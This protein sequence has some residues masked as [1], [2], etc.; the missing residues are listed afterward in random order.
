MRSMPDTQLDAIFSR[1]K[2]MSSPLWVTNTQGYAPTALPLTTIFT[3]GVYDQSTGIIQSK[4]ANKFTLGEIKPTF[5]TTRQT[6]RVTFFQT[7]C[8]VPVFAVMNMPGYK[9]DA[10]NILSKECYPVY[11]LDES[12]NQ[13]MN[14]EGFDV[15]PQQEKDSVLPNWVNALIFG[16][17]K[18][19]ETLKSYYIESDQG[20]ILSGGLLELGQRR[21]LAF[22]QFQLKG[23]DKEVEQN[24]QEMI[25]TQG[26]PA[27]TDIIK[28]A[29]KDIRNYVTK[30]AQLSAIELDRVLA[31]DSSYQM[32][33]E[34]LEKEVYYLK[35]LDL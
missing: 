32:V 2:D 8:Y 20:D 31:K 12:W 11:Y 30:Y 26:R 27:V 3:I 15:Y 4:F 25:L 7:Q 16:F 29:Q 19:D 1:I 35:E 17:I 22:E 18:Y 28:S 5:A 10:A 21:D 23:L 9:E 13:R 33:R 14:V 34:L 24:I 6:D